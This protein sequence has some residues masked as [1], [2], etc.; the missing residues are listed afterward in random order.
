MLHSSSHPP[1][2][3]YSAIKNSRPTREAC[4]LSIVGSYVSR[5][6]PAVAH[7]HFF[8]RNQCTLSPVHILPV[9]SRR[10]ERAHFFYSELSWPQFLPFALAP[11]CS[12]DHA[13]WNQPLFMLSESIRET[14]AVSN[15]LFGLLLTAEVVL[16]FFFVVQWTRGGAGEST[17][18]PKKIYGI[19]LIDSPPALLDS[20]PSQ[21]I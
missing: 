11:I 20:L 9:C 13:I 15:A 19:A 18:V 17:A 3:E 5:Y 2:K 12:M 1:A 7:V 10:R 4:I 6:A 8:L 16:F 21:N 14:V